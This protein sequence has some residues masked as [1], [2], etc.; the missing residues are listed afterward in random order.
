MLLTLVDINY[1]LIVVNI[2]AFGKNSDARILRNSNLGKC[3]QNGTLNISPPKILPG[4]NDVLPHV[5]NG[6]EAFPLYTNL[7]QSYSCVNAQINKEKKVFNYRL[8][9]AI[10]YSE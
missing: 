4:S 3:L 5:I 6:D 2:E 9:R 7:M 8:S 10:L 1:K